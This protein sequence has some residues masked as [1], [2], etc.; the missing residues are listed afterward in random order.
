MICCKNWSIRNTKHRQHKQHKLTQHK[1]AND[2]PNFNFM[3]T[4]WIVKRVN[5]W[6]LH[7]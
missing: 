6:G 2:L 5:P 1:N 3:M 7:E 4:M